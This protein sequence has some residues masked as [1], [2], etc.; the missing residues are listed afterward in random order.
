MSRGSRCTICSFPI[1]FR[2]RID[3]ALIE[4]TNYVNLAKEFQLEA[5]DGHLTNRMMAF[6]HQ[7]CLKGATLQRQIVTE[8]RQLI[9]M[10]QPGLFTD[11]EKAEIAMQSLD[12]FDAHKSYMMTFVLNDW[13]VA[14]VQHVETLFYIGTKEW[15]SAIGLL[16]KANE[17]RNQALHTYLSSDLAPAVT[18]KVQDNQIEMIMRTAEPTNAN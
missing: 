13:I 1:E 14:K 7:N 17:M 18:G 12:E 10:A 11:D 16:L 5:P 4:R 2:E 15:G 8:S 3:K 9:E 6:H